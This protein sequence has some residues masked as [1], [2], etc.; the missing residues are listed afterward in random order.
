M[1]DTLLK[2]TGS[3]SA[4]F[5]PLF[6][7]MTPIGLAVGVGLATL[8]AVCAY[9]SAEKTAEGA[10]SL[11][12]FSKELGL[13][14]LSGAVAA[15]LTPILSL[16]GISYA[17]LGA[18]FPAINGFVTSVGRNA[19]GLLLKLPSPVF[20]AALSTLGAIN[21]QIAAIA[22]A[23]EASILRPATGTAYNA[24][25]RTV[26]IAPQPVEKTEKD[27]KA[28]ECEEAEA[29]RVKAAGAK[30]GEGEEAKKDGADEGQKPKPN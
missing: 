14:A 29:E 9:F 8:S 2:L 10:F 25:E 13:N 30:A 27:E 21:S 19:F 1:K 26:G 4:A 15:L 5:I 18:R 23:I 22:V 6:A 24:F 3:I 12:N 7:S 28:K 20:S 16:A 11:Y 17:A